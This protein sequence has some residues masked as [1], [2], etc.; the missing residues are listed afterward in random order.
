MGKVGVSSSRDFGGGGGGSGEKGKWR[1]DEKRRRRGK[2]CFERNTKQ[3]RD[4]EI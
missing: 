2:S 3:K 4:D 1:T